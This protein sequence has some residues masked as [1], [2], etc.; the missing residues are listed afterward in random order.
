[1]QAGDVASETG[2]DTGRIVGNVG[3]INANHFDVGGE[4]RISGCH[5][6]GGDVSQNRSADG[7]AARLQIVTGIQLVVAG[8]QRRHEWQRVEHLTCGPRG[9][10]VKKRGAI[11]TERE[12]RSRRVDTLCEE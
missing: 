6:V 2:G 12:T 9:E 4:R 10:A 8:P 3:L 7:C 5:V 11:G 1:L